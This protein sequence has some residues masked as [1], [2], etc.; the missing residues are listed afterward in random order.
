MS[1]NMSIMLIAVLAAVMISSMIADFANLSV[2]E[3]Q[4]FS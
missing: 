4:P 1:K 3:I 2:R